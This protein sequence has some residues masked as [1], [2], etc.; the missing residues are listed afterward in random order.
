M[1]LH[2]FFCS[3]SAQQLHN[4]PEEILFGHFV[5]TLNDTFEWELTQ[6]DQGY[7][8]RRESLSIPTPFRRAPQIYHISSSGNLSFAPT[9]PCTTA[10]QHSEHFPRR[11][12]SH[13]P[14]CSHL[15]FTSSD[16]ESPV[17]TSNPCL[18]HHSTPYDSPLQ[19][20]AELPPQLQHHMDYHQCSYPCPYSLDLPHSA[21][22]DA[23]AP[24]YEMMD[25]SDISGFQDVMTTTS[26]EDIPDLEDIFRC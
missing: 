9:T 16:D 1:S 5:S 13:S 15:V 4:V 10:E 11:F 25:L 19:E 14:I 7:E 6:E 20:R 8:S 21:P 24:Y 26:D 22:E 18:Q 23:P 2:S 17:R 12:R 3:N